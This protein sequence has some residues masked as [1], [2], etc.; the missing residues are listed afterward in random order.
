MG[1]LY[2]YLL[3][4]ATLALALLEGLNQ[5]RWV[6]SFRVIVTNGSQARQGVLQP[7]LRQDSACPGSQGQQVTVAGIELG[8]VAQPL[9]PLPSRSCFLASE[10]K[11]GP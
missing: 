6:F 4:L 3:S 10:R 9:D 1:I 2:F 11:A 5:P 7:G 8:S